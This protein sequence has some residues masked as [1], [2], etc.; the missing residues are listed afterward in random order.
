[1]TKQLDFVVQN[2]LYNIVIQSVH[3]NSLK[4][5]INYI[6]NDNSLKKA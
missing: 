3:H 6:M 5:V 1:M 4:K 2:I